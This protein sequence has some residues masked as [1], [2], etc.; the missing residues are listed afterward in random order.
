MIKGIVDTTVI[1]H[2]FRK[3]PLA[4]SWYSTLTVQLAATPISWMEALYGAG[5]KANQSRCVGILTQFPMEYVLPGDMDWA[6]EQMLQKRLSQGIA[7]N[8]CFIASV[9]QRLNVPVYTDNQKDFLKILPSH[10]VVKPY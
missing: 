1:F 6:I 7:T 5:S 3:N 9:C 2:L 8:D 4:L 10:L